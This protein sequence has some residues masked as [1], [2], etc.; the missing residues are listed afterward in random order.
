M[1]FIYTLV[2]LIAFFLLANICEEFFIPSLDII[3]KKFKLSSDITGATLMAVGSSAPELF[4]SLFAITKPGNYANVGAGT[5]VGSAIFNVLV[6]TGVAAL[7]KSSRLNWQPVI[8]DMVF[9]VITILMLLFVFWDGQVKFIE[10]LLFLSLY[11]IYIIIVIN[12]KILFHYDDIDPIEIIEDKTKKNKVTSVSRQF[13]SLLIPD[14]AKKPQL[15][16]ATFS[17]SIVALA[18]LSYMLVESAIAI[19]DILHINPTIVALT[20]LAAGTSVPDLLSSTIVARQGRGDMAVS[21]AIGSNIFDILFGL[22]FPW[23]VVL[24]LFSNNSIQVSQE[25]LIGSILLLFATVIALLFLL[26]A[27]R[28][29][30]GR[31]SGAVLVG[32]YLLYIAYNIIQVI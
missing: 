6:I 7:V 19:S 25:N 4:T 11:L 5:I 30:L 32:L 20:V 15:Y 23:F 14:P 8:R 13:L 18:G 28:W 22:G 1:F 21:N 3:S 12:W 26:I 16:F 9:Y 24:V 2:L 29:H 27:R 17:M 31:L 10:A